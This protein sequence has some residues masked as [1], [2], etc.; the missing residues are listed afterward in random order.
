M[1]SEL[2]EC[3]NDVFNDILDLLDCGLVLK[4]AESKGCLVLSSLEEFWSIEL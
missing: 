3:T 4:S 1:L 2:N